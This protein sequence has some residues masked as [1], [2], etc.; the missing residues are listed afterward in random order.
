M[1]DKLDLRGSEH[2]R[3]LSEQMLREEDHNVDIVN[4]VLPTISIPDY[5]NI[6]EYG[7]WR[8][9]VLDSLNHVYRDSIQ[10]GAR[11]VIGYDCDN[12]MNHPQI[13][14][15][16]VRHL[17]GMI[18]AQNFTIALAWNDCDDWPNSPLSKM[19]AMDHALNNMVRGGVYIDHKRGC[20]D[21][22]LS[23]PNLSIVEETEYLY[24]FRYGTK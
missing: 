14:K 12:W 23:H 22:I 15:T 16:D 6:V 21:F 13:I 4:R 18:P 11:K 17:S 5:G 2:C 8:G 1:Q 7:C 9:T 20:P 3:V 19:A 10:R 24:F